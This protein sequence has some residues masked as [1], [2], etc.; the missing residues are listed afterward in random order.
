MHGTQGAAHLLE[1][2]GL[3][4]RGLAG[5]RLAAAAGG[6][7]NSSDVGIIII[8][9]FSISAVASSTC[10]ACAGASHR[11]AFHGD[12]ICTVVIGHMQRFTRRRDAGHNNS[13]DDC[14]AYSKRSKTLKL[15]RGQW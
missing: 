11:R 6:G 3:P 13:I 2:A 14:G 1:Q 8:A 7:A 10:C 4:R 9:I 5:H 12:V 15:S